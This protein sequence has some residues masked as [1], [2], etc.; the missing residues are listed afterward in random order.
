MDE[1]RLEL[2]VG[3]LV[4]A[5]VVG[6]L[7]LLWLMGELTLGRG[8]RLE[9]DFAHTGNVVKGAPVKLGGVQVG[10][11]DAIQLLP[12]RRDAKGVP[13]PVR[14][15]LSVEPAARGALRRDARVTV[16][17]VGLLGEPYLELN[18]GNAA[19]P[20]PESEAVRGVDAPRLDLLSEQ[21]SRF[22]TMLSEM[23]EKDPEAVTGLAA[24]VSRLAKTLDE[25]LSEN[26]GDVKVLASELAAASKDLRQLAQLAKESMQPGG[27]G[28]RLLDDASAVAAVMRK[29]LPGLTKSA[30][31]TL[32]GLAAVTGPLTPE[33]GQQVKLALQRFTVAAGQLEQI[34]AKADRVLG[35][36]DAGEGTGGALL[37]DPALYDELRTLVTDLRK[38]PWK[39]LWKD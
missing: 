31:T 37:K 28:A 25:V 38:H 29:D 17:T 6:V 22:V 5:T 4:L 27:K 8:G 18:P 10:K 34:A 14:M 11:V 9:V 32:D 30:G 19:A 3:A 26:K 23:L 20:L 36:L 35:R 15:D 24:N 2:K 7:V 33:D 1:Q 21:L 13:L 12:E 39:M 16:A